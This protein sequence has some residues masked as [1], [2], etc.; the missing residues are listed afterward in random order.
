MNLFNTTR[1]WKPRRKALPLPGTPLM[2]SLP[3]HSARRRPSTTVRRPFTWTDDDVDD[4]IDYGLDRGFAQ[5]VG[6]SGLDAVTTR[7]TG[8]R[9]ALSWGDG[10]LSEHDASDERDTEVDIIVDEEEVAAETIA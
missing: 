1:T 6:S 4:F 8:L 3:P 7:N 9:D 10:D 2:L 5:L